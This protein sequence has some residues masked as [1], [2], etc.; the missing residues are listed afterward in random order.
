ME[1]IPDTDPSSLTVLCR[2]T[3]SKSP[4]TVQEWVAA[5]VPE[6]A[7]SEE[8]VDEESE[9]GV[10]KESLEENDNLTL[11]AEGLYYLS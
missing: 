3:R 7:D 11:G 6:N 4:V 8:G 9:D 5:L 1:N 10:K 2:D